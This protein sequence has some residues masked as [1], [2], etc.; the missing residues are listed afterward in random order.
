MNTS[1]NTPMNT[2]MNRKTM[3]TLEPQIIS[4]Y[5]E[6]PQ[7]AE[8]INSLNQE[9]EILEAKYQQIYREHTHI[10]QASASRGFNH[11]IQA[12]KHRMDLILCGAVIVFL[13]L[14][15]YFTILTMS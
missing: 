12:V 10:I 13:M 4:F 5:N 15:Q 2:P 7:Y 8:I 6:L 9:Y 1:M 14:L 11:E 3:D